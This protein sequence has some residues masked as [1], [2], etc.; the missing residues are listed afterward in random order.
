MH[1]KIYYSKLASGVWTI[2]LTHF[3]T[4]LI[5]EGRFTGTGQFDLKHHEQ[6]QKQK[7]RSKDSGTAYH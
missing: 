4:P 7:T 6:Q 3:N 2:S 5:Q 1:I